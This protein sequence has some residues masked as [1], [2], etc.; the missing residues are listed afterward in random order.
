MADRNRKELFRDPLS[1]V[2]C[3]AFPLVMLVIMTVIN[4]SIPPEAGNTVFRIESLAPGI[5]VFGQTFLMLFTALSVSRD[6]AG[7][8]LTRLYATPARSKDFV[9]GYLLTMGELSFLQ[10]V[11]IYVASWGISLIVGEPLNPAG[12]VLSLIILQ[13]SAVFFIGLGL[14]FG[15]LFNEKSAPGLSSVV[16]SLGSFLGC[17]WFDAEGLGGA[18]LTV[19]RCLPFFYCTKVGRSALAMDFGAPVFW[20]PL[21]VTAGCAAA[22]TVIS[23]LV[24]R[25]RMRADLA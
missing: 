10:N 14:L 24:F 22:V 5:A 1:Y 13:L 11:I 17:I 12:L 18:M 6:R 23:V 9:L 2:F 4:A 8:F 7:S 3:L 21:L 19:C 20:V 15:T 25:S 16:I